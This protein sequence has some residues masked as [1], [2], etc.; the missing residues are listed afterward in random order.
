MVGCMGVK[1]RFTLRVVYSHIFCPMCTSTKK[2]ISGESLHNLL[3]GE[4]DGLLLY[5]AIPPY[6][7]PQSSRSLG[8]MQHILSRAGHIFLPHA[9]KKKKRL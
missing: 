7:S 4:K 9:T 2:P 1:N 3:T 6:S 5:L 8:L